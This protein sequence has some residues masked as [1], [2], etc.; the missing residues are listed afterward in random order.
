M[1]HLL[2]LSGCH[3]TACIQHKPLILQ[4]QPVF[5]PFSNRFLPPPSNS[6]Y[7]SVKLLNQQHC[8]Q[9]VMVSECWVSCHAP[10][11][12]RTSPLQPIPRWLHEAGLNR[13]AGRSWCCCVTSSSCSVNENF[14]MLKLLKHYTNIFSTNESL[15]LWKPN[16][17]SHFMYCCWWQHY[18]I[19]SE[20]PEKRSSFLFIH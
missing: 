17:T 10:H 3:K 4:Q 11:H 19:H 15:I 8:C 20:Q 2:F 7:S 1:N 9:V 12:S 13:E 18:W 6:S 14:C 5:P 16:N